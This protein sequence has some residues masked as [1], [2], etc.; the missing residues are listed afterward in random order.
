MSTASIPASWIIALLIPPVATLIVPNAV[1][2]PP[3]NP[4]PVLTCVTVPPLSLSGSQ[5]TDP[6]A[7]TVLMPWSAGQLPVTRTWIWLDDTSADPMVPFAIMSLVTPPV[8]M[9]TVPD[10]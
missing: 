7:L 8:A 10:V 6:S 9:L 5:I 2:G 3:D 1:I 4:M